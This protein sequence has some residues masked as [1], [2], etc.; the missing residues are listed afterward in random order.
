VA[1]WESARVIA[2][3]LGRAPSMVS[4][5]LGRGVSPAA[6]RRSLTW[7]QSKE[8]SRHA[9]FTIA[10]GIP[11]YF[12]DP[13][14]PWQ[15]GTNENTNGLIRHY[16]PKGTDL[17]GVT[18]D[19]LDTIAAKLNTRA[20]RTLGY[21]PRRNP[22]RP[23]RC[24]SQLT[25][26]PAV[27]VSGRAPTGG[28]RGSPPSLT[29]LATYPSFIWPCW[30]TGKKKVGDET[31]Y[32]AARGTTDP[33]GIYAVTVSG[34]EGNQDRF[35]VGVHHRSRNGRAIGN[36]PPEV[37]QPFH[38]AV[39]EKAFQGL[40]VGETPHPAVN[41]VSVV[42]AAAKLADTL[43]VSQR[44][45]PGRNRPATD[46]ETGR[47]HSLVGGFGIWLER[48]AI[49][50]DEEY[51]WVTAWGYRLDESTLVSVGDIA[52]LDGHHVASRQ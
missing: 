25:P 14:S 50:R 23:P 45:L 8:I 17:A 24:S 12:A 34:G 9:A 48:F 47:G 33:G 32:V 27:S 1:C 37:I 4:R 10:T 36:I 2:A 19:E 52:G 21:A 43:P 5:K 15:R 40:G 7:D 35:V 42:P 20:R 51:H 41:L 13:H 29:C 49:F 18:Q 39:S 28:Q 31:G 22:Q 3:R 38:V 16:L 46:D 30:V 26:S 11:V 44:H 6:L